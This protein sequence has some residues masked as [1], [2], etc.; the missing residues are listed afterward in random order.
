MKQIMLAALAFLLSAHSFA[1]PG[2][3][4]KQALQQSFEKSFPGAGDIH[5]EQ[6]RNGYAV[7]F[8]IE[9]VLTRITYDRKGR[10]TGSIRYYSRQFL[11]V[12]LTDK[13]KQQYPNDEI[14]GVTEATSPTAMVYFI[15]LEGARTW[16]T[17]F[18]DNEGNLSET[19]K[20]D[21]DR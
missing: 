11:P 10:F 15:K 21:K 19:E 4:V 2:P 20:F 3:G 13:I 1:S 17:L 6:N 5:W 12:N 7:E 9:S 8:R 18:I 14:F 16:T